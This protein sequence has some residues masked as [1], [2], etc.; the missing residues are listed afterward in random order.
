MKH[1][2]R[3]R[4]GRSKGKRRWK[5]NSRQWC[6]GVHT[7]NKF[8]REY[9]HKHSHTHVHKHIC[10]SFVYNSLITLVK[11][12]ITWQLFLYIGKYYCFISRFF[13]LVFYPE[14]T[15]VFLYPYTYAHSYRR[16]RAPTHART[17]IRTHIAI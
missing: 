1:F 10:I 6:T 7:L 17:H 2:I 9:P 12:C 15:S 3:N 14:S 4:R 5:K 13:S 16:A 11:I 8:T